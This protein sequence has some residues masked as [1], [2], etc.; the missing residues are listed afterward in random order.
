[1]FLRATDVIFGIRPLL[2]INMWPFGQGPTDRSLIDLFTEWWSDALL[3]S[4]R[5]ADLTFK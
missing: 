1:M 5:A 3:K 2:E 4:Q